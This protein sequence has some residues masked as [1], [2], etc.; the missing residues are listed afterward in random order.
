MLFTKFPCGIHLVC[1]SSV[2]FS[3]PDFIGCVH[4]ALPFL[5]RLSRAFL[6]GMASGPKEECESTSSLVGPEANLQS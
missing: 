4:F 3:L 1:Q 2:F 5:P 6:L